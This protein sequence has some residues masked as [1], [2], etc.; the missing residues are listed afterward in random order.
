MIKSCRIDKCD[1]Y[2]DAIKIN[3]ILL[4]C[5]LFLG[6][7]VTFAF[8]L[9]SLHTL[10]NHSSTK[11]NFKKHHSLSPE[12]GAISSQLIPTFTLS[13]TH[14]SQANQGY[15]FK[16]RSRHS[17]PLLKIFRWSPTALRLKIKILRRVEK[18]WDIQHL[19][20]LLDSS[21]PTFPV[22]L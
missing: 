18:A 3:L 10:L 13:L 15:L 6:R 17:N 1:I 7:R 19:N 9:I 22:A 5:L 20:A 12:T 14:S 16:T 11:N 4:Q 8:P 21:H 2:M